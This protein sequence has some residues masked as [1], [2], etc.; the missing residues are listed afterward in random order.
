MTSPLNR[1]WHEQHQLGKGADLNERVR[2][3]VAHAKVCQCRPIPKSVQE[4]I[5]RRTAA[6]KR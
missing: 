1:Q 6:K 4:E 3:H 5:E 2:W